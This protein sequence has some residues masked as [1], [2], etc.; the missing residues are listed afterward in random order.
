M[1][2]HAKSNLIYRYKI[3]TKCTPVRFKQLSGAV[4]SGDGYSI[5]FL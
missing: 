1:P 3:P 4:A 2:I 5:F